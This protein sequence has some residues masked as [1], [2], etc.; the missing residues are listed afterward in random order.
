MAPVNCI[1]EGRWY[2]V[3]PIGCLISKEA[4]VKV[5]FYQHGGAKNGLTFVL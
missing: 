1:V 2:T 4:L 3:P 5:K